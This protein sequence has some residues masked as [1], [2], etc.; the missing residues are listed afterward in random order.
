MLKTARTYTECGAGVPVILLQSTYLQTRISQEV[1]VKVA[2]DVILLC[3]HRILGAV[4]LRRLAILG[5][6]QLS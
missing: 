2:E 3:T 6:P 1:N 5:K 4:S